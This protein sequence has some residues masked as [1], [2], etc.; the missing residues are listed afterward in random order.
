MKEL[1]F[2]NL[3]HSHNLRQTPDFSNLPNLEKLILKDCPS[4]SSVSPSIGQ[5]KKILLINLKDCT[6]LCELSRSIYKLESVKTLILFGCTKIDKLEED[7]EQMTSL[8][9]LVADK[10]SIT[11]APFA[12]VRSKSIGFISLCGFKG[13]A[14]NVFPSIIQSWTSPTNNILSIVQ[15]F[16]GTSSL[17]FLDEQNDAFYGLPSIFKDLQNLQRL[18]LKCESEAQLKQTLASILDNLHTNSCEELEAMENT[19]Q[20]SNF[21]NSASTHSCSQVRSSSS[22]N[23]LTSLLI[24]IGMNCRV[25]NTLKENIF[26]VL[27]FSLSYLTVASHTLLSVFLCIDDMLSLQNFYVNFIT[28]WSSQGNLSSKKAGKLKKN[29]R[30]KSCHNLVNVTRFHRQNSVLK[31]RKTCHD[32]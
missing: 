9:T 8:T 22:Q 5:L 16:A 30:L 31:L 6:G 13:F 17:E 18:W 21:V 19:S 27:S 24:Q 15:T 20:F 1:K 12:L 3:S 7:I 14:R 2:L 25:T 10:T 23:F 26:Q 4:L 11:T 28:F 29:Q 32:C